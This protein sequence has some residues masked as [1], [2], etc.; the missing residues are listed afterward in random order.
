[1][2]EVLQTHIWS[3]PSVSKFKSYFASLRGAD[4]EFAADR[5]VLGLGRLVKFRLRSEKL[6][7]QICFCLLQNSARKIE[8]L[9]NG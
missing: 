4:E 1:M 8:L 6:F 9:A 3:F 2:L 5:K 7:V